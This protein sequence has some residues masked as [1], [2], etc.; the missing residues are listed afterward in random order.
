MARRGID[1][2]LSNIKKMIEDGD[3]YNAHLTCKSLAFRKN[4][5]KEFSDAALILRTGC[6]ELLKAKNEAGA[7][8]LGGLLI[9]NYEE[10][11][12]IESEEI[13]STLLRIFSLFSTEKPSF[14]LLKPFVIAAINWSM[15]SK[16]VVPSS[17]NLKSLSYPGN[18]KLFTFLGEREVLLGDFVSA[19]KHLV[20]GDRPELLF[21]LLSDWAKLGAKEEEDLFVTRV[22]LMYLC[23]GNLKD[24][25][26]F[27]Q[28]SW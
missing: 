26:I 10:S 5:K 27:F 19:Q 8:D 24:A 18:P 28:K 17:P 25:N 21:E 23:I 6:E 7:A 13:I 11:Q 4:K 2:T 1:S 16:E 14:D 3:Y 15:K 20:K 9:R 12:T 22:V